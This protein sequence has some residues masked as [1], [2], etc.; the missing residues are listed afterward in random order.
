MSSGL[1]PSEPSTQTLDTMAFSPKAPSMVNAVLRGVT[2]TTLGRGFDRVTDLIRYVV[3]ARL[4][5]FQELGSFGIVALVG[6]GF[7]ALT[8]TGFRQALIRRADDPRPLYD[9][10]FT[11]EM[12]RGVL[13]AAITVAAAPYLAWYLNAP[14][15]G[16]LQAES[17]TMIFF[18]AVSIGTI[19]FD[20]NLDFHKTVLMTRSATIASLVVGIALAFL[21]KNAWA[22]V[23]A[24]L[25]RACVTMVLS[26]YLHPY[27]PRFRFNRAYASELFTFGRWL[28]VNAI[29]LFMLQ[30]FDS[31]FLAMRLG[32]TAL[33]PYQMAYRL[34]MFPINSLRE[35]IYTVTLPV[36]SRIIDDPARMGRAYSQIY[37]VLITIVM[38]GAVLVACYANE[39]LYF[40]LGPE[41]MPAVPIVRVLCVLGLLQVF[42]CTIEPVFQSL[43]TPH[44]ATIS[45]Y[46]QMAVLVPLVWALTD[47]FG[48]MG[49][50]IGATIA[51]VVPAIILLALLV[52]RIPT[53]ASPMIASSLGIVL[54]TVM[55]I[56]TS[57]FVRSVMPNLSPTAATFS[58]PWLYSFGLTTLGVLMSLASFA[59]ALFIMESLMPIGL[60]NV[61]AQIRTNMKREP[62]TDN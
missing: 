62:S 52:K 38:P 39:L 50:A 59:V 45:Q 34:A 42:T 20:R 13:L 51:G 2:W 4:L 17:L 29:G 5:D 32:P 30:Q 18:G 41:W 12:V 49:A 22:L 46:S 25:T 54:P 11:I 33:A 44:V 57:L 6:M 3:L 58:M 31:L 10:T 15:A 40:A 47:N 27:R 36:F 48:A 26:Y 9:T 23:I 56:A 43:G 8:Y 55:L 60:R 21:L 14:I 61:I 24:D 35:V 16:L 7:Q 1:R 28:T 19:E 53:V 37:L